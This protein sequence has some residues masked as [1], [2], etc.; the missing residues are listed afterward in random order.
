MGLRFTYAHATDPR[1]RGSALVGTMVVTTAVVGLLFTTTL[2]STVDVREARALNDENLPTRLRVQ[3][4]IVMDLLTGPPPSVQR[5]RAALRSI[6]A[7]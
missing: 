6:S 5:L 4:P 7:A 1:R 2:I 3:L